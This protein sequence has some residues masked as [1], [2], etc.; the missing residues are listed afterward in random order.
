MSRVGSP[1][2]LADHVAVSGGVPLNDSWAVTQQ[3]K[4]L[5]ALHV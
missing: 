3:P 1:A 5:A 2:T 4:A